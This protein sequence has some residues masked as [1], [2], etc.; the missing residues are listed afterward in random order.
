MEVRIFTKKRHVEKIENFCKL[1][2]IKYKIY[3]VEDDPT[4]GFE[5]R[6]SVGKEFEL[7]ISYCYPR[8]ILDPL[9]SAPKLGFI[10]FHPG[11]LPDYKAPDQALKAIE[12]QEVNWGVTVHYMSE[13]YDEGK[14]IEMMPI[15]LHE[16]PTD[17]KELMA[18]T[19]YF[20]F[21]LF[22]KTIKE[23]IKN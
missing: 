4:D 6:E 7:G 14:I 12:K 17:R 18:V 10:N 1:L 15:M 5:T 20:L 3:T 8:K 11:K 19:H 2:N 21:E 13:Q 9:L 16:P 22:K 23:F